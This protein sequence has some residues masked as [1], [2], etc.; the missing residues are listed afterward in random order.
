MEKPGESEV[1]LPGQEPQVVHTHPRTR[2]PMWVTTALRRSGSPN[3]WSVMS[4]ALPYDFAEGYEVPSEEFLNAVMVIQRE[5]A[6]QGLYYCVTMRFA[7][8]DIA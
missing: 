7:K 1:L 2:V 4:S 5:I 8:G 6:R 3:G